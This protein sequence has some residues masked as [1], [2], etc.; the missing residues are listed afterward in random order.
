MEGIN[1]ETYLHVSIE[2]SLDHH[3]LNRPQMTVLVWY[4]GAG[5]G[6][7]GG[8]KWLQDGFQEPEEGC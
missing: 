3:S 7:F 5:A 1:F 2:K 8:K 4:S 6:A